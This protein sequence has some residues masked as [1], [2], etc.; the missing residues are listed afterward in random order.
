[1]WHGCEDAWGLDL[2]TSRIVLARASG[3]ERLQFTAQRNAFVAAPYS[4][5]TELMLQREEILHAADGEELLIYG[6]RADEFANLV[7]GDTRRPMQTGLLN[8]DEPRSLQMIRLALE[9]MCGP[10]PEG[11]RMC[12]SAP[13]APP[14]DDERLIYHERTVAQIL[15]SMGYQVRAINEGLAIVYAELESDNFTGIGVSFGGGMC[16]VC[17]AYLGLPAVTFSTTRAGDYIDRSAA[18]ASGGTIASVRLRKEAG[19]TLNGLSAN[20]LDQALSV[21]YADVIKTAVDSLEAGL[22]ETRK[23]PKLDRPLTLAVAGGSALAGRFRDD[24]E[25]A[26]RNKKLPVEIGEVRMASDPLH[27]TARGALMAAALDRRAASA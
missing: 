11:A 10:A 9:R 19:F 3:T 4:R 20:P 23:L 15:E 16:N 24:L 13:A 7:D 6:N 14:Q 17:L 22:R 27:A 18:T 1:M 21:Y 8:P 2:G 5:V 25:A 26:I 12:F